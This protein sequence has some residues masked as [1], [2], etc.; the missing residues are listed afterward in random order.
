M[1]LLVRLRVTRRTWKSILLYV[2]ETILRGTLT[3]NYRQRHVIV[4]ILGTLA[5]RLLDEPPGGV[6]FVPGD[7][8]LKFI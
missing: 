5:D 2:F 7:K 6:F 1:D 8:R 3:A 4:K